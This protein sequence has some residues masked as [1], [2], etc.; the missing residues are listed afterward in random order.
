MHINDINPYIRTPK[1]K[2]IEKVLKRYCYCSINR[3]LI[4]QKSFKGLKIVFLKGSWP[5]LGRF[6]NLYSP[7]NQKIYGSRGD[8]SKMNRSN[9]FFM[10]LKV[11]YDIL[12]SEVKTREA[13]GFKSLRLSFKKILDNIKMSN[14]S[15][16]KWDIDIL[17]YTTVFIKEMSLLPRF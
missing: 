9:S 10:W 6:I 12:H 7:R 14:V 3:C 1:L 8:R 17:S 5:N 11:K 13:D 16:F 15:Q 4:S 2:N